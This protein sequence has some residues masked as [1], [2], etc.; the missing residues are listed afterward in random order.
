MFLISHLQIISFLAEFH[1][2]CQLSD[3]KNFFEDN[4]KSDFVLHGWVT[5]QDI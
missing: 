1:S 4:D 3:E 5:R 2:R